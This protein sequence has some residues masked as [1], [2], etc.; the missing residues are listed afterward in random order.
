MKVCIHRRAGSIGSTIYVCMHDALCMYVYIDAP[1]VLGVLY[2]YVCMMYACIM[3]V[4][5]YVHNLR[6]PVSDSRVLPTSLIHTNNQSNILSVLLQ[7]K[8][9]LQFTNNS[10]HFNA[11]PPYIIPPPIHT[12]NRIANTIVPLASKHITQVPDNL[13]DPRDITLQPARDV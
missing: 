3:Y 4:C 1:R 13:S 8:Y 11:D 2:M 5:M 9:T 12:A 6:T 10:F 7:H